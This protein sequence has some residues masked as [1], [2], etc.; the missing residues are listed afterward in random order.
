MAISSGVRVYGIVL[1]AIGGL[2]TA[3]MIAL[4]SWATLSGRLSADQRA[5]IDRALVAAEARAV[6]A[7]A[8]WHEALSRRAALPPGQGACPVVAPPPKRGELA[9]Q[10]GVS[11]GNG[12]DLDDWMRNV[13]AAQAAEG[14]SAEAVLPAAKVAE[15]K[16][17]LRRLFEHRRDALRR[18]LDNGTDREP[19]ALVRDAEALTK[20]DFWSFDLVVLAEAQYSGGVDEKA[21]TFEAGV[22][23]G[24]AYVFDYRE[25]RV[26]CAGSVVAESSEVVQAARGL[27]Q[28]TAI[29]GAISR[30]LEAHLL[31]AAHA[32]LR[33][34]PA[35]MPR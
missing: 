22:A 1:L 6:E 19:D 33:A 31:E 32:G 23:V 7:D 35:G 14:S 9:K 13:R 10:L 8:R 18:A 12:P 20:P 3:G 26:T 17:P 15:A 4:V 27:G 21:K 16:S 30:D 11:R 34:I 24:E 5:R 25:G 2:G 29:Y 28:S